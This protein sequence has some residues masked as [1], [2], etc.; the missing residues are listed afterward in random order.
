MTHAADTEAGKE[1]ALT[2]AVTV[3][4]AP[5][6]A[7][8]RKLIDAEQFEKA[9]VAVRKHLHQNPRDVAALTMLGEIAGRFGYLPQAEEILRKALALAP[10]YAEAQL[11]LANTLHGRKQS[12][13]AL[14]ILADLLSRDPENL[15]A[16]GFK[17]SILIAL[18]RMD[19]GLAVHRQMLEL[20]PEQAPQWITY[21]YLLKTIGKQQESIGAYRQSLALNPAQGAAWWSLANLK[22]VKFDAEDVAAMEAGLAGAQDRDSR[23]QLHFALGKGLGDQG[24]FAES[25]DHYALGNSLRR[26]ELLFD[27]TRLAQDVSKAKAVF[28]TGYFAERAGAGSQARDPIF[29]VSMHRAGSTLIEQ[30]LASHPMVEG[31]EELFDIQNIAGRIAGAKGQG[32]S[33]LDDISHLSVNELRALGETYLKTTRQRR[34]TDRPYFTDKMPGNWIF[35]GLIR[36]ILPN[37]RIIDV[38]RH[39]MACCFANFAQYYAAGLHYSYDL[40]DLGSYYRDYLRMMAHFDTVAPGAIYRLSYETIVQNFESEVRRLL[41]YLDLPFDSACLRFYET[42]RAIHT[43]SSEQVR[44]P[45]NQDGMTFWRNYEPWLGPLR[46]AL[47]SALETYPAVPQDLI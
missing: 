37:A 15:S 20:A 33:W 10:A 14:A 8:A 32:D 1:Q 36:S 7:E 45:I 13:E 41:R 42:D 40:E 23:I 25:F 21:A 35:A 3:S 44:Q 2:A 12:D 18:R 22:T 26:A 16:L 24:R 17:A 27:N 30:I 47:G 28:T 11:H 29:I 9:E 39:P 6:L 5:E 31:T 4:I 43:P 38:R 19:D 34:T 46:T